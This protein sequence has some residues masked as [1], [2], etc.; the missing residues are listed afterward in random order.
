MNMK[1]VY[2]GVDVSKNHLDAFNGK[3]TR[4]FDN[5]CDGAVA[6]MAWAGNAHYVFESTGGYERMAAWMVLAAGRPASVVNPAR[7][8]HFALGMGQ[9]AKTDPIDARMIY[10]F[11]CHTSPDPSEK[12]S[13]TQRRLTALVDRRQQLTDMH[14]AES[15]RLGS[16]DEPE[17]RRLIRQHLKWVEKQ[18]EKLEAK[19]AEAIAKDSA[20]K[21]KAGRIQSIKGLGAVSAATLLAHLPEIGTLSRREIAALAGLAPFNRDSGGKSAK[22]HVCGGRRRLRSCLYMA[23]MSAK[24]YNPVMREFYRRL[25]EENHRPKMVALTAVMRKLLIAANSAVKNPDF[26]VAG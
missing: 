18:L 13:E 26:S 6:L 22:R 15:N 5:T 24:T 14:T 8:R 4:E 10:D 3:S 23:A 9:I 12:P 2:C 17:L 16:A 1:K 11:A 7:V 21:E 20:L 19:I 25:V